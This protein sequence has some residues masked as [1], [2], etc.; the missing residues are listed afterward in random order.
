M[1][2]DG[3]RSAPLGAFFII[4]KSHHFEISPLKH[5]DL[6]AYLWQEHWGSLLLLP[7]PLRVQ[8]LELV[9]EISNA[10]PTFTAHLP[11]GCVDW[12]AVD[13]AMG[14]G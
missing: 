8:A 6:A 4:K 2:G 12:D 13:R 3:P 9:C 11:R 1:L 10:V 7:K 14:A 5:R